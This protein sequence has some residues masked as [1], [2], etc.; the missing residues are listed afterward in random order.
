MARTSPVFYIAPSAFSITPNCNESPDDLAVFVARGTRIK[1]Y[2]PNAGIG[3]ADATYREW[4]FSGRNRRLAESDKPYTIYARLLRSASDVY[5]QPEAYLV[6][7]PKV[8]SGGSWI[9]PDTV[10]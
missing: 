1:V 9:D 6:F 2:S 10:P 5:R 3:T 8:P 7:A 4:L